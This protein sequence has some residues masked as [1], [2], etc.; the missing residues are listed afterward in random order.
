MISRIFLTAAIASMAAVPAASQ[1][2]LSIGT[3]TGLGDAA[4]VLSRRSDALL[5]NPALVGIYDGP[6]SSYSVLATDLAAAPA[7][8]WAASAAALGLDGNP[9]PFRAAGNVT[10]GAGAAVEAA[11]I[12]WLGTQH[13]DFAVAVTTQ[14]FAAGGVP[15]GLAEL[16]GGAGAAVAPIPHDSTTRSAAT[17][18]SAG[19]A[20]HVGRLPA[21]G[22]VWLG[23]TAKGWWTHE[24]ARGA[25]RGSEPAEEVYREIAVRNVPG[26]GLDFG[27][28]AQPAERIRIGGAISNIVSGAFRPGAGPRVRLVSVLQGPSGAAEVNETIGPALGPDDDGTEEGGMASRLW[29]SLSFPSVLRGGVA[30]DS[31]YGTF[32]GAAR[33]VVRHGGLTPAWDASAFTVAFAGRSAF[34]VNASYGWGSGSQVVSVGLVAGSCERRWSA[35]V[36]RRKNPWGTAF[37]AS[38]GVSFGSAPGC[39]VFLG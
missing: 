17:V 36:V 9:I 14:Q 5:W 37:G 24:Y 13:R 21:L 26:Y 22:D 3:A 28:V 31:D 12:Q 29:Q 20:S 15:S 6:L 35:G 4:V 2:P 18:L 30:V 25:F 38:A 7:K 39:D 33:T 19:R 16:L 27:V 1:Q 32:S 11:S 8:S 10:G 34:P 23:V